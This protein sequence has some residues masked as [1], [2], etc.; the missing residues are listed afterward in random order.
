[1]T[2][3]NQVKDLIVL[4][5]DRKIEYALIGILSR[6]QA[7]GIRP[8][9]LE[10]P[11]TH[12]EHD[13]GC[14]L[15]GPD[16]LRF[17][18]H[19]ARYALI[20]MDYEGSGQEGRKIRTEMEEDLEYRLHCGGW[21]NRAAAIVIEPEVESW[22]WSD[23]PH[24]DAVTGWSAR[25]PSLRK[26]L[27]QKGWMQSGEAKPNHPKEAL[28]AALRISGKPDSAALYK[29]LAERVSIDR[30][31]DLSFL[32]LKTVLRQWFGSTTAPQC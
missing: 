19:R 27:L 23:S 8:I 21:E 22:V 30:C 2:P 4:S 28:K 13:P 9:S 10:D 11:H 18:V 3:A 14:F 5:A 25:H 29:K 32:K 15:D 24:V 12:P 6:P 7:I 17:A 16:F 1:M 31:T 20:V 26:W